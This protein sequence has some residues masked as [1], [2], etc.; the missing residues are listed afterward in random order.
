MKIN[1]LKQEENKC[2]FILE[3]IDYVL[4]NTIRRLVINQVPVLAIEDIEFVKNDSAIYDEM[5]AHRLG[6]IPLK[7]DLKTYNL[8]EDCKCK[9]KG[10]AKCQ[11]KIKM[12][13]KG[14]TKV[15]GKDLKSTDPKI[16]AVYDDTPIVI[17]NEGQELEF[18]ATAELG[19]GKT[20][21][22][23]VPGLIYYKG[24]PSLT[25]TPKSKIDACIKEAPEFLEKKG[26]G[27]KIK[28]LLKWNEAI[29]EV[30]ERNNIQVESSK[31]DFIFY[32]ESWGQLSCNEILTTAL[33]FL[34][35]KLVD[36]EK[37]LKKLKL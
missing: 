14:P 25:T 28:D 30:C 22:K 10:C 29:E 15:Y 35:K 2:I 16:K 23:Y 18:L 1:I 37:Q 17:L 3:D 7:T 19:Q 13:I 24:V 20:H 36:F 33:E 9:G 26:S 32:L 5:L 31:K 4:A 27:I 12:N 6:L 34:D 8:K 11:L 21:A